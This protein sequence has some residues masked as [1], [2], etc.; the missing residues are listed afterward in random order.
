MVKTKQQPIRIASFSANYI[1]RILRDEY[2]YDGELKNL[3]REFNYFGVR[4]RNGALDVVVVSK[5]NY[6]R[7]REA[8]SVY[9]SQGIEP[10]RV[11][12]QTAQIYIVGVGGN[13]HG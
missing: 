5:S 10:H 8:D 11:S 13:G 6:D 2:D 1:K 3:H 4:L 9:T 7:C 12:D